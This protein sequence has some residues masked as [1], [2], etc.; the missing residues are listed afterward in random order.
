MCVTVGVR[1]LCVCVFVL[2]CEGVF[3]RATHHQAMLNCFE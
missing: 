2:T 3:V 1:F